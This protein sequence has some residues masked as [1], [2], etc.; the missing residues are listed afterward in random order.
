MLSVRIIY[1]AI[2]LHAE[3]LRYTPVVICW[4][5][6]VSPPTDV[7]NPGQDQRATIDPFVVES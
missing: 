5:V 1:I 3:V 4:F 7:F 2:P 6:I